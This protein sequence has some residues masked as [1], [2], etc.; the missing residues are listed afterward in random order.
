M[1]WFALHMFEDRQSTMAAQRR[2]DPEASTGNLLDRLSYVSGGSLVT[3]TR[4]EHDDRIRVWHGVPVALAL[5]PF[6]VARLMTWSWRSRGIRNQP[7]IDGLILLTAM[8]YLAG[9]AVSIQIEWYRYLVPSYVLT[10]V[11]SGVGAAAFWDSV[12]SFRR[13]TRF[14]INR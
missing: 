14:L 6:G 4:A 11:I 2:S 3:P 1:T 9:I 8:V 13:R 12:G 5:A 10:S 7:G